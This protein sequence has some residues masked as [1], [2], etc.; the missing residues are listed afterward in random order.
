MEESYRHSTLI[1]SRLQVCSVLVQRSIS[2]P[3]AVGPIEEFESTG[4]QPFYDMV[5]FENAQVGLQIEDH[6]K[7][8]NLIFSYFSLKSVPEK[9]QKEALLLK[10]E[11]AERVVEE[12]RNLERNRVKN[13]KFIKK[14]IFAVVLQIGTL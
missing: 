8:F 6:K 13:W 7:L 11:A 12:M 10:S 1:G 14:Y 3:S 4:L 9:L 2:T 5:T